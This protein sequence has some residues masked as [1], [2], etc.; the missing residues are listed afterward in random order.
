MRPAERKILIDQKAGGNPDLKEKLEHLV[1]AHGISHK[2]CE[3]FLTYGPSG[4]DLEK[5]FAAFVAASGVNS[6]VAFA[7]HFVKNLQT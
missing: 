7:G 6:F 3:D 1:I 2:E 5:A 4:A